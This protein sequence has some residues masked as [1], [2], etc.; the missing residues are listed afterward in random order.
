LND[1]VIPQAKGKARFRVRDD[2]S[3]DFRVEIEDLPVGDYNLL[4]GGVNQGTI[5]VTDTGG[6][7]EGEIEFDTDPD[8]PGELLL[9]FDIEQGGTVFLSRTF[10]G[11]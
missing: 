7:T 8:D 4:V 3:E 9:D 10:P 6:E 5:T 11:I 1:G 2:C